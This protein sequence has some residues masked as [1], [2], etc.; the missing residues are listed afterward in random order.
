MPLDLLQLAHTLDFPAVAVLLVTDEEASSEFHPVPP[1]LFLFLLF[2]SPRFFVFHCCLES[3]LS[4]ALCGAL[5]YPASSTS[6]LQLRPL[7][8][9]KLHQIASLRTLSLVYSASMKVGYAQ[10]VPRK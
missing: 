10:N 7:P 8:P 1:S 4:A 2:F 6:S 3:L 5:L 9:A